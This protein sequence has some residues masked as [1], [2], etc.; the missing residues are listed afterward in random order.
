LGSGF[1]E[2]EAELVAL[3]EKAFASSSQILIDQDLRGWKEI[4]YE[5]VRDCEDNCVTVCN[6][7][8]FDPLGIH[9]GDSIV[10]APSQ[11]LSNQEYYMLRSTSIKVIRHLGIVGECNIQFALHPESEKYCI[12]EVNARLSR[13]SALASKATGYPLAYVATKL[14]LGKDLVSIRNSVTKTTTACFEPSL[15]Y[16]VVK[17]PRW[18]LSKFNRVETKLVG[19]GGCVCV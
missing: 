16:C 17:M 14:C 15:D 2:N 11:T 8:N 13:S 7:E 3:A 5:V 19:V 9:T 6:M 10:V 12:I 18:D 4:E 1:A